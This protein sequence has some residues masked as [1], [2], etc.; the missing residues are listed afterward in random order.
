MLHCFQ[1]ITTRLEQAAVTLTLYGTADMAQSS[2]Q[3]SGNQLQ[4]S[5]MQQ[6]NNVI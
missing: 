3:D 2:M 1:E 6:Y 4:I 5:S